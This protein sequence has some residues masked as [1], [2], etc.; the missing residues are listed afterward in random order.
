M[1]ACRTNA[2]GG[3]RIRDPC[4]T[5][6]WIISSEEKPTPLCGSRSQTSTTKSSISGVSRAKV[7]F[8][9]FLGVTCPFWL[10]LLF[11]FFCHQVVL[12]IH[13]VFRWTQ[14]LNSLPG[15]M[16]QTLSPQRSPLDQ[17]AS[18]NPKQKLPQSYHKDKPWLFAFLEISVSTNAKFVSLWNY[19]LINAP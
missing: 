7:F 8:I 4:S 14:E 11:S 9:F 13:I 16:A 1:S 15:T 5:T 19:D 17:G 12:L 10:S 18:P 2:P 6:T 3:P